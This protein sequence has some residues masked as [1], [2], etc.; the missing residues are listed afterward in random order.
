M[1]LGV[2]TMLIGEQRTFLLPTFYFYKIADEQQCPKTTSHSVRIYC[3]LG[4]E[5]YLSVTR[6]ISHFQPHL[7]VVT[8]SG[9]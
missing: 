1:R 7:V 8:A 9:P 6:R 2:G 3:A 5:L 4:L